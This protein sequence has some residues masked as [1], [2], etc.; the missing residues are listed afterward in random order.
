MFDALASIT[1]K[2]FDYV[3]VALSVSTNARIF[4]HICRDCYRVRWKSEGCF[5]HL[6]HN[7]PPTADSR[8]SSK[9]AKKRVATTR[10]GL[11]ETELVGQKLVFRVGARHSSASI[12][13]PGL[14]PACHA[15]LSSGTLRLCV[16]VIYGSRRS[17]ILRYSIRTE[18]ITAATAWLTLLPMQTSRGRRVENETSCCHHSTFLRSSIQHTHS[19][20]PPS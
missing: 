14:K 1:T 10:A 4:L 3:C 19:C 8:R 15:N 20:S 6:A 5:V 11:Q 2:I 17:K 7:S 16:A 9:Q 12:S 13:K 18:H